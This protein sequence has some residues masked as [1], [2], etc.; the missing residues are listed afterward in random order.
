MHD[1]QFAPRGIVLAL[2]LCAACGQAFAQ[3]DQPG[4]KDPPSPGANDQTG[5]SQDE[6]VARL[7]KLQATVFLQGKTVIEVRANRTR[8]TNN[9]LRLLSQFTSMT[10]LSLEDTRIT[11]AGLTH[12][13]ML[14]K[15]EWLNLYR[16]RIGDAG[17]KE[18]AGLKSLQ[19]LPVGETG[20]SDSGLAHVRDLRQ[21]VYLGLRGNKIT[22]RGLRQLSRLVRLQGLYLGETRISDKGLGH[23]AGLTQLRQL[24]LNDTTVSDASIGL[25]TR[26]TKLRE[27]HITG[28]QITPQGLARLRSGLPNCKIVSQA[29][30]D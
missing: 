7:R 3:P 11:A 9:D 30:P 19:H 22:D 25:L 12:L 10:D 21:L 27:L 20:I 29:K 16:C 2:A 26:F 15:L 17:L 5:L 6:R 14:H 13:R 1:F 23:L 28:T 24:W 4:S 18:L 8:I